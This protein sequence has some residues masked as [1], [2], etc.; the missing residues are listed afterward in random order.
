MKKL[1]KKLTELNAR[2]E[3]YLEEIAKMEGA[4]KDKES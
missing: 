2:I 4:V 3:H 1:N